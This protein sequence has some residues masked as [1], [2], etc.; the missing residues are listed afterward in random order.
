MRRFCPI[1]IWCICFALLVSSCKEQ[2][3]ELFLCDVEN[4]N[5]SNYIT[6]GV[7]F[8]Q[9]G[10]RSSEDAHKGNYSAKLSAFNR[11]GPLIVLDDIGPGDRIV[12]SVFR[13][14]H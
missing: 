9:I 12:Y 14:A 11:Y 1:L 7:S 4:V 10:S 6:D 2:E 5:N 8:S 3:Y 13:K